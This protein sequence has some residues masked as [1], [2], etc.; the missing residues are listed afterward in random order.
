MEADFLSQL[1]ICVLPKASAFSLGQVSNITEP[2]EHKEQDYM[3]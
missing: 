1:C 3:H 2:F